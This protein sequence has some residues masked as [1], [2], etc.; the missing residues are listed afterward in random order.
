MKSQGMAFLNEMFKFSHQI[1]D[2]FNATQLDH[3]NMALCKKLVKFSQNMGNS[4]IAAFVFKYGKQ[5][6]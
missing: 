5:R 1:I 6:F 3:T 2:V 4:F